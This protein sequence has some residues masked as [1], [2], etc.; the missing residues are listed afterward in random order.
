MK[1]IF[2]TKRIV[3]KPLPRLF[4]TFICL[5]EQATR[6]PMDS[7]CLFVFVFPHWERE[8][9]KSWE[10]ISVPLLLQYAFS[11]TTM[12][13]AKEDLDGEKQGTFNEGH[14]CCAHP[15]QLIPLNSRPD[16]LTFL[17]PMILACQPELFL[18]LSPPNHVS[19]A[20][21]LPW[22]SQGN[23]VWHLTLIR[24]AGGRGC[25]FQSHP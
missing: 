9:P 23:E 10:G 7:V 13:E 17:L 2:K 3:K 19:Q 25:Q 5:K 18:P 4:Y 12:Q 15:P 11:L 20:E 16:V 6:V 1:I 24:V 21:F 8:R 22:L 14:Q